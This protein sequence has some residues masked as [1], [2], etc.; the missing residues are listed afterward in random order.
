M[1]I[2]EI[3]ESELQALRNVQQMVDSLW[4]DPE[5]GM[6]VK[7]LVKEKYPNANIPELD[8][9]KF[10]RGAEERAKSIADESAKILTERLEKMESTLKERDDAFKAREE[11]QKFEAE[12]DRVKRQYSLTTEGMEKVFSRMKERNNPDVESAAAWVISQEPKQ[13]PA[14]GNLFSP[15]S[16]DLYG[17]SSGDKEWEDLNKAVLNN[18]TNDWFDRTASQVL[19]EFQTV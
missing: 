5:K 14:N 9:V 8:A 11:E 1:S 4:N 17:A 15:T 7:E 6:K 13:S 19:S 2:V 3:Q 18:K 16:M 12:V 10:A